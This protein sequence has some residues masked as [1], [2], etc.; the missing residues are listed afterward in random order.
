MVV[1]AISTGVR[2]L[3]C[4]HICRHPEMLRNSTEFYETHVAVVDKGTA[5]DVPT[6]HDNTAVTNID[7]PEIYALRTHCYIN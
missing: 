6:A 1:M 2:F 7:Q 3:Q 4:L 5:G